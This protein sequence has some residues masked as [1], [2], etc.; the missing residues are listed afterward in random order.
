MTPGNQKI[1][2]VIKKLLSLVGFFD[3]DPNR[4]LDIILSAFE[5]DYT[6]LDYL[7]VIKIFHKP[8]L[9][10]ILGFRFQNQFSLDSNSE[11][12]QF[13]N[14]GSLQDSSYRVYIVA[15][16]LIKY[17]YLNMEDL[18]AHLSSDE[19]MEEFYLEKINLS[20]AIHKYYTQMR[21]NKDVVITEVKAKE[22]EKEDLNELKK[23]DLKNQKFILLSALVRVNDFYHSEV[24]FNLYNN[25]FDPLSNSFLTKALCDLTEWMIEPLF[26]EISLSKIIQSSPVIKNENHYLC[27]TPYSIS[28]LQD[29]QKLIIQL[30]RILKVLSVGL[31]SNIILFTK[32]C[33]LIKHHSKQLLLDQNNVDL[34]SELI[35][36]VFLPSL[37]LIEE[38]TPGLVNDIWNV[39]SEFETSKRYQF[40]HFWMTNGYRLHPRL[41]VQQSITTKETN[42]WLKTLEKETYR[43]NGRKL[44]VLT[45]SNPCIVFDI[46][47]K[48]ILS[49]DNQIPVFIS[50]LSYCSNLSYDIISFIIL[51]LLSD[52][53]RELLHITHADISMWLISLANFVGL[54]YKKQHTV[55]FS[56][57]LLYLASKLKN[58][59][60]IEL[61]L[62]KELLSK[63][64]GWPTLEDLNDMQI[65]SFAGGLNLIF[66]SMNLSAEIKNLKKSNQS[67]LN[68]FLSAQN[69]AGNISWSKESDNEMT[70]GDYSINPVSSN[71]Q[72]SL[73]FVFLVLLGE[74]RNFILYKSDIKQLKLVSSLYDKAQYVFVQF[75][76]YLSHNTDISSYSQ[77]MPNIPFEKYPLYFNCSPEV[78]FFIFR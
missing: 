16:Q 36:R 47:L 26:R 55:E 75:G 29:P 20:V 31:S 1:E 44:G 77:L 12:S 27:D 58:N 37:S 42:K 50:T 2:E 9:P 4:V 3:L 71:N 57:L 5:N 19:K 24:L 72:L 62:L 14:D 61:I 48:T 64:S 54:F 45:N 46:S 21:L 30:V 53:S 60:T 17:G 23:Q 56:A 15:A 8:S 66:E 68:F 25:Y 40:Y 18:L 6:N 39:L 51:K 76:D 70:N 78:V 22:K 33:R 13:F 65:G 43:Q 73:A 28:Q 59:S 41:Y 11:L 7:Q 49:Y 74:K 69:N 34:L 38:A 10:H 35:I 32:I 52:P 63:M 67:L